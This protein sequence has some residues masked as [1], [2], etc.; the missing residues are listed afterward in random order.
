MTYATQ[1]E[2]NKNYDE[3]WKAIL[4]DENGN[5]NREQLKRELSDFSFVLSQASKVY[6]EVSGG[7]ISKPNT[8]AH[9]VISEYEEDLSENYICKED[10]LDWLEDNLEKMEQA[11]EVFN[12]DL[13]YF[14][15]TLGF[16]DWDALK[17]ELDKHLKE[18]MDWIAF[19]Q[20][21]KK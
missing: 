16:S 20:E 13:S 12:L 1:E 14:A 4:E 17:E 2:I 10:F 18:R 15:G 11:G 19:A 21:G 5:I 7:R 3:F 8:Y 9:A 6:L